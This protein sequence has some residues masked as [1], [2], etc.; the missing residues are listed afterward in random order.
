MFMA[1]ALP[2]W[3]FSWSWCWITSPLASPSWWAWAV[4]SVGSTI[5][6]MVTN[7]WSGEK[8]ECIETMG[9]SLGPYTFEDC[10]SGVL[11]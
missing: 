6:G 7:W 9:A 10:G 8:K 4:F 2:T 5:V 3:T 11:R 1:T